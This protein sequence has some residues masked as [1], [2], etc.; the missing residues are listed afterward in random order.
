MDL[1]RIEVEEVATEDLD[2]ETQE[3]ETDYQSKTE[4]DLENQTSKA[5]NSVDIVA[6]KDELI[7]ESFTEDQVP[8]ECGLE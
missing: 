4:S 8:M 5:D 2:P 6:L 7:A 3:Y 1:P